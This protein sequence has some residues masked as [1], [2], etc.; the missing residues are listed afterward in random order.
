MLETIV[1]VYE[2]S[3]TNI[4]KE[5]QLSYEFVKIYIV[6]A[7]NESTALYSDMASGQLH[8]FRLINSNIQ[9]SQQTK[10]VVR[11]SQMNDYPENTVFITIGDVKRQRVGGNFYTTGSCYQSEEAEEEDD[12]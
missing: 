4:N 12:N 10:F 5:Y 7:S 9:I 11:Q 3:G 8:N 6:P 1:D 2:L